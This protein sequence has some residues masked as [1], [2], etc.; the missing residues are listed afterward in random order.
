MNERRVE[1]A[2]FCQ[3]KGCVFCRSTAGPFVDRDVED[4]FGNR[5]YECL[6]CARLGARVLGI[7]KGKRQDELMHADELLRAKDDENHELAECNIQLT[8]A[9]AL[10]VA[11]LTELKALVEQQ[12]QRIAQLSDVIRQDIKSQEAVLG[13]TA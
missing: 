2:E 8:D 5:L 10:M 6:S 11:E 3:T 7:V 4:H 12:T 1:V 13:A 9:N